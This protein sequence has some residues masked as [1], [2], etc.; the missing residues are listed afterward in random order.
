MEFGGHTIVSRPANENLGLMIDSKL[1][2]NE[3]LEHSCQKPAGTR[4]ELEKCNVLAK[5]MCVLYH[6]RH[7]EVNIKCRNVVKVI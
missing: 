6:A 4:A 2:F 3:H 5:E 1:S 7:M